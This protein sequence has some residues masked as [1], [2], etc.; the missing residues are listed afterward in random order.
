M[1]TPLRSYFKN[2]KI[3]KGKHKSK[4]FFINIC[5]FRSSSC[6]HSVGKQIPI[7]QTS[8]RGHPALPPSRSSYHSSADFHIDQ[9]GFGGR[10]SV[11]NTPSNQPYHPDLIDIN[12]SEPTPAIRRSEDRGSGV[13][14]P[15]FHSI[16]RSEN[17][18]PTG[19]LGRAR[20]RQTGHRTA[21][22][23]RTGSAFGRKTPV[24]VFDTEEDR[25]NFDTDERSKSF[26]EEELV[27]V[28]NDDREHRSSSR[29]RSGAA[30]DGDTRTWGEILRDKTSPFNSLKRK[31]KVSR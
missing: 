26:D 4:F 5:N 13:I 16:S 19:G 12:F 11:Q 1:T 17:K 3:F 31:K 9:P 15:E 27:R 20:S 25:E 14:S 29:V 23:H 21:P 7:Q 30:G 24:P 6:G 22:F 10:S 8:S 18:P 2:E 28:R